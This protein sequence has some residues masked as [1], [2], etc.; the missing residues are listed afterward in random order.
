MNTE[1]EA[2]EIHTDNEESDLLPSRYRQNPEALPAF[3]NVNP[4]SGTSVVA[5]T[6]RDDRSRQPSAED[7]RYSSNSSFDQDNTHHMAHQS[8]AVTEPL[9]I[10][11]EP[12]PQSTLRNRSDTS[13]ARVGLLRNDEL[14]SRNGTPASV[15]SSLPTDD[16]MQQLRQQMHQVREMAISATEQAQRMHMLI[17]AEYRKL[18]TKQHDQDDKHSKIR[19][20]SS[21]QRTPNDSHS[22]SRSSSTSSSGLPMFRPLDSTE[23][24]PTYYPHENHTQI[25]HDTQDSDDDSDGPPLGCEHYMRNI[26]VQCPQCDRFYT[27]RHCHDAVEDHYLI[28]KNIRNILCMLCGLPQRA[29]G[30]CRQCE[31]QTACYYCEV[32]KLWDNDP[33]KTIYHCPDCGICRRGEGLGKDYVH[34]SRCNV[35][36]SIQ[37]AED[38]HCVERATECDCPICGDYMFTSAIAVVAM[39]CG[40]YIHRSCYDDLMN[41]TYKCPICSRSAVNMELQWRKMDEC[42]DSQPMPEQYRETQ[43]LITCNDCHMRSHVPFHWLGNKCRVCDS[44]NTNQIDL[45]NEPRHGHTDDSSIEA[46][47]HELAQAAGL[48]HP[49]GDALTGTASHGHGQTTGEHGLID[50]QDS[51]SDLAPSADDE[52]GRRVTPERVQ[53]AP[54]RYLQST[55]TLPSPPSPLSPDQR[56]VVNM[57]RR[58]SDSSVSLP[59][60]IYSETEDEMG[61]WGAGINASEYMP[62]MPHLPSMPQMPQMPNLPPMPAMPSLPRMPSVSMPRMPS[63]WRSPLMTPAGEESSQRVEGDHEGRGWG[64]DPRQWRLGSPVGLFG[65]NPSPG[66]TALSD[67]ELVLEDAADDNLDASFARRIS[68]DPRA[69]GPRFFQDRQGESENADPVEQMVSPDAGSG[70]A[71]DPRQWRFANSNIFNRSRSVDTAVLHSASVPEDQLGASSASIWNLHPRNYLAR[72]FGS[73]SI[74][75]SSDTAEGS[76]AAEK[77]NGHDEE[78]D[79]SLEDSEADEDEEQGDEDDEEEEGAISWSSDREEGEGEEDVLD[80]FGHR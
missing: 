25:V 56:P 18:Q 11:Y 69:W 30:C 16:G 4:P 41:T 68:W 21:D 57:A 80:L 40:H 53:E 52:F 43:A 51:P 55:A 46:E 29:A 47:Q 17:T 3:T 28:R 44:Y 37:H 36:V 72:R 10:P 73:F 13:T 48:P 26:K 78:E 38:H 8:L 58:Y 7:R 23:L 34:C 33:T 5:H 79:G 54:V 71:I 61:F 12:S 67:D 39:K 70:W 6:E 15:A 35:C 45:I 14:P 27:C 24:E 22:T 76:D 60:S 42:L 1:R 74:H 2:D 49:A 19:G 9:L 65:G 62:S 32:C 77:E 31:E 59:A 64:L 50:L 75:A 20:R 63:G 66:D